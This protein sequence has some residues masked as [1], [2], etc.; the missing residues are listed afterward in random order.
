MQSD[1][2]VRRVL[3]AGY[4]DVACVAGSDLP[5]INVHEEDVGPPSRID[6]LFLKVVAGS[7]PL[8]YGRAYASSTATRLGPYTCPA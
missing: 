4:Q 5:T 6:Y 7:A 3:Q 1:P 8:A 2:Q